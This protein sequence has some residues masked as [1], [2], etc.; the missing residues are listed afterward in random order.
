MAGYRGMIL[1]PTGCGSNGVFLSLNR[2][3]APLGM[4]RV[5]D[6]VSGGRV[7]DIYNFGSVRYID[8]WC[9]TDRDPDP[10]VDIEL[11]SPVLI[12]T[13]LLS[14]KN[15]SIG[16]YFV[17]NFTLEYSPPNNKTVLSYYT[18]DTGN[19][20]VISVTDRSIISFPDTISTATIYCSISPNT[21]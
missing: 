19:I 5:S 8:T 3:L 20:K 18:T 21:T 14:G 10:Y 9:T 11:T 2:T 1:Q 16:S 17:T 12:T 15:S 6:D 4:V 13:I 7:T